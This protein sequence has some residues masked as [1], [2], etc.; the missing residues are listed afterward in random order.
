MAHLIRATQEQKAKHS[1][2]GALY[3]LYGFLQVEGVRLVVEDLRSSARKGEPRYE[4]F[5]P[6]GY[7]FR[8]AR[9]HSSLEH[10]LGDVTT[11]GSDPLV[12]CQPGRLCG[13]PLSDTK[14][15]LDG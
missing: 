9:T 15:H 6:D 3:P 7:H 11:A 14:N 5:C 10:T 12:K 13:C 4:V 1:L 2:S 8:D